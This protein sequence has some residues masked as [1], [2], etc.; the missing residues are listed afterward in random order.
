MRYEIL[1]A[2][3][4]VKDYRGLEARIRAIVRDGIEEYLRYQPT[5]LS[6]SR[7]KRLREMSR[8]QY[9]LRLGDTRVFYDVAESTVQIIAIVEKS[10]AQNWLEKYGE[11]K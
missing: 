3:E 7:I 10:S 11:G 4:A 5:R 8:P 9:R 1:F 6:K 2:P